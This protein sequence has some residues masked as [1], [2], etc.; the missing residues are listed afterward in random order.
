[1]CYFPAI[2]KTR[3]GLEICLPVECEMKGYMLH[4]GQSLEESGVHSLPSLTLWPADYGKKK[5]LEWQSSIFTV[6][7]ITV[8]TEVHKLIPS[9]GSGWESNMN[10]YCIRALNI[11]TYGGRFRMVF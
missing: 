7:V 11:L 1:M 8:R 6:P 5:A 4:L 10:F 3:C 2:C 9:S